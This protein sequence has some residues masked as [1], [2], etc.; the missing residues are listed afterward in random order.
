MD[1]LLCVQCTMMKSR[2]RTRDVGCSSTIAGGGALE[3][4]NT[5]RQMLEI[6]GRVLLCRCK[7]SRERVSDGQLATPWPMEHSST[8]HALALQLPRAKLERSL[9]VG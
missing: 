3:D 6:R 4:D 5:C 2:V 7:S 8:L 1:R 9:G